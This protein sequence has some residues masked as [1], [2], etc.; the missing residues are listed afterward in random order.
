MDDPQTPPTH[1]GAARAFKGRGAASNPQGRFETIRRQAE[2]DGWQSALLDEAAPRPQTCVTEE[3]A[4]SVISRNDSPDIAFS[5]AINPYR[6]CEHGCIYCFARPSHSYLNLSPGLD[7]ETRL[8]AKGNLAEVLRAELAKPGYVI[9]PINIG[10]NTDP[11]QPV[12]KRWRLT[13]AALEL[14]AECHHPC[15]IVTKNALVER[16]L[17]I[18]APMASEGLVQVFVSVN[19][20]DNHLAAKLEPRAS[21][22]HRRI[23]AIRTLAQ[24]GVPVGVLV[25]PIIPALNDRDMEAVMEQAADA[26]ARCA[27]YT[28]LRLPYELKQLFREWLALHAPRRAA[29]VMSLVQQMNGGLDYDSN[30][31]TRMRGRGVFADL[32]RRRFDLA[33]R[34]HGLDRARE[35]VLDVSRFVPPRKASPQGELF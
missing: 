5:Q 22:P 13:R 23:K 16:D 35:L 20:L 9:S 21:A 12:E 26:G 1:P 17:D 32:L 6:G 28:T 11:Y 29:H 34:R 27:G 7:F 15:T 2:D 31:A 18:L 25:A 33:C 10:S 8:R 3:R 24:A 30:F 4:R 14:L 19:S